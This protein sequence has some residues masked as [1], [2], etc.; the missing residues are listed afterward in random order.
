MNK[1]TV[2]GTLTIVER[3]RSSPSGNPRFLV[4]VGNTLYRT[5]PDSDFGY[6][7]TNLE[8]KEVEVAVRMYHEHP[9]I[10]SGGPVPIIG[11]TT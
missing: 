7:V 9:S 10:E 1:Q 6:D 8:G 4:R 2:T 5:M 11:R 3:M